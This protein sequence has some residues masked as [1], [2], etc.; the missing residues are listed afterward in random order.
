[1]GVETLRLAWAGATV[2][3]CVQPYPGPLSAP[4]SSDEC[5]PMANR[6]DR[7]LRGLGRNPSRRS[8]VK[9]AVSQYIPLPSTLTSTAPQSFS[10]NLTMPP[11]PWVLHSLGTSHIHAC[12][13]TQEATNSHI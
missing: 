10:N 6:D 4:S 2:P 12:R 5:T 7:P 1:M 3:V 11:G 8:G 9:N 13:S